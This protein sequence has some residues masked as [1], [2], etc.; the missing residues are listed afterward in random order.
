MVENTG[1][2]LAWEIG[3]HFAIMGFPGEITNHRQLIV[4]EGEEHRFHLKNSVEF[5]VDHLSFVSPDFGG[6]LDGFGWFQEMAGMKN[7]CI[8]T[9]PT[10]M[11]L[12]AV[13]NG[14]Y[15]GFLKHPHP[16]QPSQVNSMPCA[17]ARALGGLALQ[18]RLMSGGVNSNITYTKHHDAP[19]AQGL[20]AGLMATDFWGLLVLLS[21]QSK[22]E[23]DGGLFTKAVLC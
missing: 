17:T 7:F 23:M 19:C 6:V 22:R 12:G 10:F 5:Y 11:G 21:G 18:V 15:P 9:T 8:F 4:T 3:S 20:A 1:Q 16:T 2:R 14:C 13:A